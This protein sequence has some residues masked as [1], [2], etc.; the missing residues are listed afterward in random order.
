[1]LKFDGVEMPVPADLQV[2]DNKIWSDNTGRSAN[3]KFVGESY[4]GYTS[5]V[6]KSHC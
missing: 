2:Q 5:Q 3:G 1:M 4:R 6:S